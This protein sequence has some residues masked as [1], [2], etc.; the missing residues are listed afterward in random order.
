M[1]ELSNLVTKAQRAQLRERAR[2]FVYDIFSDAVEEEA[3]RL[4]NAW[5]KENRGAIREDIKAIL[6]SE[7]SKVLKKLK[8]SL[9][10][11]VRNY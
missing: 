2:E 11:R 1:S 7:Y 10:P 8:V 4:A 5:L 3:G 9:E 6:D